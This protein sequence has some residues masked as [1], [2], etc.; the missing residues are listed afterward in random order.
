MLG[1][2]HVEAGFKSADSKRR[3]ASDVVTDL[4]VCHCEA[5]RSAF[6]NM[7]FEM[8]ISSAKKM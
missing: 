4:R 2:E 8:A 6:I 3:P 5:S 1:S 7:L